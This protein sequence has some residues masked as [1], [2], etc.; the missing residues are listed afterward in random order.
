MEGIMGKATTFDT[1][2]ARRVNMKPLMTKPNLRNQQRVD[3]STEITIEKS[4]GCHLNCKV[5]NISR[6]GVMIDCDQET[7][8]QL[9]PD[10]RPPAPGNLVG[11]K[12]R[13]SVP[14]LPTQPVTVEAEGKIVHM[15]RIARNDFQVGLQFSTFEGNG[16]NYVDQYVAKLLA[17]ARNEQPSA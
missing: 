17:D 4:D 5:S 2:H 15:R 3:V 1:S 7:A 8:K 9:V 10:M 12:A 6:T 16:F 14:V 13:F 11:V